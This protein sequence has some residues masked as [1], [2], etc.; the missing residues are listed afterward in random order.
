MTL[1]LGSKTFCR[2]NP[3]SLNPTMWRIDSVGGLRKIRETVTELTYTQIAA[4]LRFHTGNEFRNTS[5]HATRSVETSTGVWVVSGASTDGRTAPDTASSGVYGCPILLTRTV[6]SDDRFRVSSFDVFDGGAFVAFRGSV[7]GADAGVVAETLT[8]ELT[9][10]A[11]DGV[12]PRPRAGF[13]FF[14]N[15]YQSW[16]ETRVF[17]LKGRELDP[18]LKPMRELQDNLRNPPSG[19]KGVFR[20]DLFA[21]IGNERTGRHVLIGSLSPDRESLYIR[22][23]AKGRRR[24]LRLVVDF[25]GVSVPAGGK[26]EWGPIAMFAGDNPFALIDRYVKTVSQVRRPRVPAS[27]TSHGWCSWYYYFTRV[28]ADD[29]RENAK[30]LADRHG[31]R[32][33]ARHGTPPAD[34]HGARG[35]S[36]RYLVLD[37]GYHDGIGDWTVP[38]T[39]FPPN[40]RELADGIRAS[41]LTPGIW[42]APLVAGRSSRLM[43]DHP[44]WFLTEPNGRPVRAAWNP[45]WGED[46]RFYCLDVGNREVQD[47]LRRVIEVLVHEWGF[48][49]LKLDFMYAGAAYGRSADHR[50]TPME[51]LALAY[52]IIRDAAGENIHILGCG[53]P[54]GPA[55][56]LVDS[57]RTGPDVAPYWND[58]IRH[59]LTRDPHTVCTHFAVRNVLFRSSLHRRWWNSDPDCLLLRRQHTRLTDRERYTLANAI[60]ITGGSAFVSDDLC[61]YEE[62]DWELLDKITALCDETAAT[63][64]RLLTVSADSEA[65]TVYNPAGFVACFN[66]SDRPRDVGIDVQRVDMPTLPADRVFED[67]WNERRFVIRGDRLSVGTLGARESTL[68]RIRP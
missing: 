25:G 51:R 27:P 53:S 12:V 23:S 15:G 64:A 13:R 55:I 32:G 33:T 5:I 28:D 2:T 58:P 24:G 41:H 61:L 57:M 10:L 38:N 47:H 45:N 3:H 22:T 36:V 59:R 7:C 21:V 50:L 49:Y 16:S 37:D 35:T 11:I 56:G 43:R 26:R 20:S 67:V 6:G 30:L 40:L 34:R 52:R 4:K 31:A 8:F 44:Y 9:D 54:L 18:I 1:W 48:D 14:K 66:L 39:G 63:S 62:R 29:I 19:R 68:L 46:A 60:I 42:V 65:V 17:D